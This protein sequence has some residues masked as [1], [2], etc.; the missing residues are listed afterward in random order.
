MIEMSAFTRWYTLRNYPYGYLCSQEYSARLYS[1]RYDKLGNSVMIVE[2]F[3]CDSKKQRGSSGWG[4]SEIWI[5]SAERKNERKR[6]FFSF[7]S[8]LP[9]TSLFLLSLSSFSS[10]PPSLAPPQVLHPLTARVG[11]AST[12][13]LREISLFLHG[14]QKYIPDH[15]SQRHYCASQGTMFARLIL[16]TSRLVLRGNRLARL[17]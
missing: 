14:K 6:S 8:A 2:C 9:S 15:E 16:I 7:C 11:G 3:E 5:F 1:I 17:V 13:S 12:N 4:S 10:T